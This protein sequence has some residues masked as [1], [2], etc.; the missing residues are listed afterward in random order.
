MTYK[1]EGWDGHIQHE[2]DG[3]GIAREGDGLA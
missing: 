1:Q 2:G 3:G